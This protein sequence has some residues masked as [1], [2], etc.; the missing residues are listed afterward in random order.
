MPNKPF[1]GRWSDHPTVKTKKGR[2]SFCRKPNRIVAPMAN[3]QQ[4]CG[5]C[6]VHVLRIT[7]GHEEY[8]MRLPH[9]ASSWAKLIAN[10]KN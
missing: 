4:F 7:Y 8:E 1:Y 5:S 3:G 9:G 10:G 2:C 6:M